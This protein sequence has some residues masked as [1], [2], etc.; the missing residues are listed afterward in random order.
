MGLTPEIRASIKALAD[1]GL[2]TYKIAQ[3]MK[4]H[5]TTVSRTL[6]R[7]QE[8]NSFKDR[9]GRGRKSKLSARNCRLVHRLLT[10]G[11]CPTAAAISRYLNVH[12]QIS[13]SGQTVRRAL[14]KFGFVAR[15]KKKKPFLTAEHKKKR[16]AF[17]QKYKTWTTDD[18]KN[19]IFSDETK[20][21]I[22]NSDGKEYYWTKTPGIISKDSVKPT[23]KYGG[24]KV[25]VWGCMTWNGVGFF[26][27][28]KGKMNAELYKSILEDQLEQTIN[29]YQVSRETL[30]FQHDNDPKHTSTLVKNYL[31]DRDF[32]VMEWP[33]QSPDLNPIEHLWD[34]YDRLLKSSGR[35]ISTVQEMEDQLED[36]F[37]EPLKDVCRKLISTMPERIHDVIKARG[38]H[39][40]W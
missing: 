16:L 36:L 30:T 4:V 27:K 10:S 8:L 14:R 24:G 29:Y 34:H 9:G 23:W 26:C 7:L 38:G 22:K 31:S 37:Q 28:I 18:W 39:T 40:R 32:Q 11:Q 25:L 19:V 1:A 35:L 6:K 2:S 20:F 3:Q 17:A 21:N 33:S 15:I 12:Y 13:V 5:R